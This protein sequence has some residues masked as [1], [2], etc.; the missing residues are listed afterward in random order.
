VIDM[1][2]KRTAQLKTHVPQSLREQYELFVAESNV[3]SMSDYLFEVLEEH[4][5]M[6]IAKQKIGRRVG[7]N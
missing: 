4:A 2:E 1:R 6:R 3:I 5:A 7:R